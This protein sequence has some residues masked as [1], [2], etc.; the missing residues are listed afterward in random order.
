MDARTI[1]GKA[2]NG[3]KN[4]MTPDVIEYGLI[5]ANTAYELSKGAGLFSDK[6][7]YGVTICRYEDGEFWNMHEKGKMC[8]SL[9]EARSYIEELKAEM[10]QEK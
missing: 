5:N 1:V 6:Q 9:D 3:N 2:C 7:I 4:F 8:N 10:K